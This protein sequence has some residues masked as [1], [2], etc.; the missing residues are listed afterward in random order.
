MP[1]LANDDSVE[2]GCPKIL[3]DRY[4]SNEMRSVSKSGRQTIPKCRVSFEEYNSQT[5]ESREDYAVDFAFNYFNSRCLSNDSYTG[6]SGLERR[7]RE[8]FS[9]DIGQRDSCVPD[10][11]DY[12][13]D[14]THVSDHFHNDHQ[15]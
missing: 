15:L 6:I 4:K 8:S 9:T 2:V 7:Y 12:D 1:T 5:T 13:S 3:R 11:M 14:E 10:Q